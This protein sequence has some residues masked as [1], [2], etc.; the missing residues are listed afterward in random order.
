MHHTIAVN[1]AQLSSLALGAGD[2]TPLVMLHGLI[3]GNMASWYS[4]YATPLARARRVL[5]YDQRGHGDSSLP[6]GGFD[7]DAQAADLLA[8]LAH[9]GHADTAVDIVGHSMG[10]LIALHFA[11]RHPRRVQRLV[12]VDAPMPARDHVAPSLL[13]VTSPEA[14]AAYVDAELPASGRRRERLLKRL[15]ALFFGSTLMQDVLAM[16]AEPDA[17]LA[18]LDLPVLLVYGRRSPCLAAG[19]RLQR[20]LPRAQLELIDCGHYIPEEAPAALR[21]QLDAFLSVAVPTAVPAEAL[22]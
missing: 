21:A 12:L 15:S 18:A 10:A 16:N 20:L 13:G 1:G 7:L 14:L 5:L 11:L 9:H 6:S 22:A 4:A 2:G 17:A 19:H 3:S 8:V